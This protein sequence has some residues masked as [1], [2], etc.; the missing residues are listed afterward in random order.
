MS[1]TEMASVVGALL[2]GAIGGWTTV[3]TFVSGERFARLVERVAKDHRIRRFPV[4]LVAKEEAEAAELRT[5]LVM[6]GFRN[7]S[8]AGTDFH[9]DG[10]AVVVVE[11]GVDL[12]Q[13]VARSGVAEGL[14]FTPSP[15]RPRPPGDWTFANSPISL[16]ARLCELIDWLQ[17]VE[18]RS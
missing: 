6:R 18:P 12:E 13:F 3:R 14:I 1:L 10:Q 2:A 16:F 5:S 7:V 15:G 8:I 17:S 4:V 11:R 9:H